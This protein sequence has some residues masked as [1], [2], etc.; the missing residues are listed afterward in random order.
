MFDPSLRD[1]TVLVTGAAGFI[2]QV[3]TRDLAG[4]G[5]PVRAG[6]RRTAVALPEGAVAIRCDLANAAATR[7]AVAGTSAV[8]HAAYGDSAT[9]VA[10]CRTLLAAMSAAKVN[11][12]VYFSSI[13]V[14][15]DRTGTIDEDVATPGPA[16]AYGDAKIACEAFVRAWARDPAAPGR[17]VLI[18]R[19]G[20]VYG[21]GSTFW[22]DKLAE[23]IRARAWGDFGQSGAGPAALVHVDD[24]GWLVANAVRWL[25]LA[26]SEWQQVTVFNV[27]GPETPRWNDYFAAL[28]AR[29]GAPPLKPLRG[30][31][32]SLRQGLAVPA[33]VA[34]KL[35]L[36]LFRRAA[37]A[38]TRPE[39]AIFGRDVRYD[40]AAIEAR[41]LAPQIG[42]AEGLSRTTFKPPA[43]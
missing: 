27:V 34:R 38:P 3:A 37:L 43:R 14:Y 36:P 11:C 28:A 25:T 39:M 23:R 17:R 31:R 9:M 40:T 24:I 30:L 8:V 33:K 21:T 2:G 6:M 22:V 12:L 10:E 41:G 13:A 26:P 16:G 20:I 15:G 29:I 4:A 42:V 7:A 35:R 5:F 18:L 19:P 32:L 1:R